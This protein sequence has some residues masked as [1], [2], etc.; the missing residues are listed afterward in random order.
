MSGSTRYGA[1]RA[2]STTKD[3]SLLGMRSLVENNVYDSDGNFVGKLE[4]IVIDTRTG[5]VRHAVVAIGGLLGLGRRR[6][7][8][9]WSVLTPDTKYRRC[10]AD[11]AQMELTAVQIPKGDPWL[12]RVTSP[13]LDTHSHRRSRALGTAD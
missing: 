4:E 11:V 3:G 2:A 10:I 13:G 9:P 8:V 6:V 7:A 12:Q 1:P 5:C